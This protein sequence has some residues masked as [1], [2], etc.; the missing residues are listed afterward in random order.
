MTRS[1]MSNILIEPA[2]VED[3]PALADLLHELFTKESDF[4]PNQV[5]QLRGLRLIIE[6][7]NKGRIFVLRSYGKLLGMINLLF[8]ISTAEGGAVIILEDLIIVQDH[9]SEGFGAQLLEYAIDFARQKD[10]LRITLLT[11][12]LDEPAKHFFHRHGFHESGMVPMRWLLNDEPA[13]SSAAGA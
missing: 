3:L 8:T 5:K 6:Q 13:S 9:R 4:R 11:D 10:F 7:P 1:E 12:R 2:T